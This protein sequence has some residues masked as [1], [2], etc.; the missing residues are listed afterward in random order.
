MSSPG[1]PSLSTIAENPLSLFLAKIGCLEK[2]WNRQGVRLEYVPEGPKIKQIRDFERDWNFRARMK[3]SSEPPS[4][5]F[6][7]KLRRQ[8]WHFRARLKI[9]IEIENFKRDWIFL[10]VGPSGVVPR[11][12]HLKHVWNIP[13]HELLQTNDCSKQRKECNSFLTTANYCVPWTIARTTATEDNY[14][15]DTPRRIHPL[16]ELHKK[17]SCLK[18]LC[19]LFS[20]PKRS[21]QRRQ[22]VREK[23]FLYPDDRLC[24]CCA[25]RSIKTRP[26]SWL[27]EG[28]AR[29]RFSYS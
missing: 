3:F 25:T 14:C 2:G 12:P 9:S 24:K 29:A 18:S 27:I 13:S 8:D 20:V 10:I 1:E 7:G 11:R 22:H 15:G 19:S 28:D 21:G 23:T 4:P 26:S 17:S 5:F 6:V 16:S